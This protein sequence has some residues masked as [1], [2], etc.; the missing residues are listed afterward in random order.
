MTIGINATAAF[1]QPRTGVEEYAYQL[2]KHLTI[3]KQGK[4]HCFVLYQDPR[5]SSEGFSLADNFEIKQLAWPLPMWTQVRLASEM[6]LNKPDVLFIPVHVLP[7]IHPKNSVVT[8]HGL[9]YEYYPKMYH[10]KHL[11]YLRWITKYA[12]KNAS[13]II[14]VS[15]ATKR[16]LIDL[17]NGNPEKITVVHHGVENKFSIFNF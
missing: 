5:V 7:L 9:E 12:L 8:I 16:D 4:K 6:A 11:K 15:E 14:A 2:V 10:W 17:Y 13:K 1:K 3:L